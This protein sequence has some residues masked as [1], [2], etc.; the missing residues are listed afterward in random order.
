VEKGDAVVSETV[1][2]IVERLEDVEDD[3][4][5][6]N[7]DLDML[8]I[9]LAAAEGEAHLLN[10][11]IDNA[12]QQLEGLDDWV[13]GFVSSLRTYN[14]QSTASHRALFQE[15][16]QHKREACADHESLLGKLARSDDV[17]DKKFVQVDTELEKVVGLVGDKIEKEVG[18]IASEFA[19]AMDAEEE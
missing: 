3:M 1:D 7:N 6:C 10:E 8:K 12:H 16:H 18:K 15:M 5:V 19:E 9:R 13:D 17:I 11:S 4:Q 14:S 2:A